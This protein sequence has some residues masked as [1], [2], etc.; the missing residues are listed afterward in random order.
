M[1]RKSGLHKKVS[2]I[3]GDAPLPQ[4]P[5]E[6]KPPAVG[7]AADTHKAGASST[8]LTSSGI[9]AHTSSTPQQYMPV[10]KPSTKTASPALTEDQE[11]DAS[12]RRKLFLTIGLA[13]ILA[14]VLFVNLYQP[15]KKTA[16]VKDEPSAPS[17]SMKVSQI[18]WPQPELWPADTRDP[19]VFQ[20]DAVRLYVA[21]G[22]IQGPFALRG[23]V[24]KPQ[25]GSMALIGTEILYE[26]DEINGWTLKEVLADLVR[27]EN[28]E[29]EKLE[30]KMQD[31]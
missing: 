15:A 9:D 6:E 30:L 17:A 20:A 3:F 24:H 4:N 26:G 13:T 21:E 1:T 10:N 11:Y 29:G 18:Y 23:I 14:V 19:M 28:S 22:K 16:V 5:S 7:N 12:Q 25:G 31:R 8:D 2:S 27:F